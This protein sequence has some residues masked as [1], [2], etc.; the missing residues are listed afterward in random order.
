MRIIFTVVV[1][2]LMQLP[3][4]KL[5]GGIVLFYI[6][7]KLL[8]PD[9]PSETEV[10]PG[11]HLWRAV[12]VIAIADV[13]MSLDNV[14]AIAAAAQGN[15]VLLVLGLAISIPLIV[16]GAAMIMT[17]LDRFPALSG[18]ARGYSGGSWARLSLLIQLS[19][20]I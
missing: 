1:A 16:A 17:L 10:A 12:R 18:L 11:E 15:I 20:V 4:L 7:A 8:V 14:I 5:V 3:Y 2:S 13:I 9:N 19:R 6:A